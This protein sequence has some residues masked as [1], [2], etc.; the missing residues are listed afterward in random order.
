LNLGRNEV[1]VLLYFKITFIKSLWRA[2]YVPF[3]VLLLTLE[4]DLL[5]KNFNFGYIFWMVSI[6]VLT[7][8]INIPYNKIFLW[9]PKND[10]VTLTFVFYLLFKNFNLGYIFWMVF[11]RNLIF[12]MN[13]C[14]DKSFQWVR[15]GLTLWPWP[16][17]LIYL[18]KTLNLA[19]T[20]DWYKLEFWCFTW[21]FVLTIPFHGYQQVWPCVLDF[22]VWST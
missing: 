21:V 3:A 15:I 7:F 17:C 10:L 11:T 6:R 8:H 19:V 20:F 16:L 12:H 22:C 9:V 14:C 1:Q 18:L 5:I 13:V 2:Y 4:F